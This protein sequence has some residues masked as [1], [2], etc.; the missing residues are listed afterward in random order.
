MHAAVQHHFEQLLAGQPAPGIDSLLGAFWEAWHQNDTVP[1]RFGKGED[2]NTIGKLAERLL[3]H[4]QASAFARPTGTIIG[5]EE[6]L[7]G[8]L[9]TGLPEFVGRVDLLIE[10]AD[11][12][13][14]SDFKTTRTTWSEEH[15]ADSASQLLLYGELAKKL[16]DGKPLRLSFAVLTKNKLPEL[17][18]HPVQADNRHVDRTK[19]I[20]EHVWRSIK[21]GH[22]YPSPSP[23]N[24]PTC[25]YRDACRAW[26]G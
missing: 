10:T 15:I 12:L 3:R 7:R 16:T 17:T 11:A 20:F 6:E 21:G 2:I 24:C 8:V 18:I 5:V 9:V 25:P 1:I 19:R 14:L 22:F 23:M 26:A 4:F 13:L